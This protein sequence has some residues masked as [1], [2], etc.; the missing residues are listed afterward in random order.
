[1]DWPMIGAYVFITVGLI[2]YAGMGLRHKKKNGKLFILGVIVSIL[3][4]LYNLAETKYFGWHL[5]SRSK[6]EGIWDVISAVIVAIGMTCINR[7][8]I[9]TVEREG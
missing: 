1:M 6:G 4:V 3:G 9:K 2:V 8:K 5:V 7:S